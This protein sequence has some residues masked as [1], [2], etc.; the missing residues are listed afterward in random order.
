MLPAG[1]SALVVA[2]ALLAFLLI[3]ACPVA[4]AEFRRLRDNEAEA[5]R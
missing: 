4:C 2:L 5:E 3:V 1:E